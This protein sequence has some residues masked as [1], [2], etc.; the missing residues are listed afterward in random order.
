[1]EVVQGRPPKKIKNIMT[2]IKPAKNAEHIA[3][4]LND[5]YQLGYGDAG[6]ES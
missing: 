6:K 5:A 2:G 1:M 4:A 3:G